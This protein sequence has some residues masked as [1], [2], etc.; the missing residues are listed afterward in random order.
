MMKYV[1]V[2]DLQSSDL[3]I[4]RTIPD[5]CYIQAYKLVDLDY[6]P[7]YH[8]KSKMKYSIGTTK[9]IKKWNT[10]PNHVCGKGLHV[11]SLKWVLKVQ[12]RRKHDGRPPTRIIAVQ[13]RK[14][15]IVA[16]PN[17]PRSVIFGRPLDQ[18]GKFRVKRL[19]VVSDVSI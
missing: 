11:A 5:N 1:N 14:S 2:F 4:I 17:I 18:K 15:D 16:I 3:S 12:Q 19:R 8:T 13:F 9:K 6:Q 7:I 10:N